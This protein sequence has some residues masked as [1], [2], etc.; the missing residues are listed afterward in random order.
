MQ[1]LPMHYYVAIMR[2]QEIERDGRCFGLVVQELDSEQFS[3]AT[4]A[5]GEDER[6][7]THILAFRDS[8][9]L[10][11]Y[12]GWIK[13]DTEERLVFNLGGGKE[14]EFRALPSPEFSDLGKGNGS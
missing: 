7:P 6:Q 14:Y 13:E 4:V 12:T 1:I 8:E 10:R 5:T 9:Q 2:V 3:Y 11:G